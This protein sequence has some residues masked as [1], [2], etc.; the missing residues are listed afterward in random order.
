MK[1]I[2]YKTLDMFIDNYKISRNEAE[3]SRTDISAYDFI[4]NFRI[5]EKKKFKE[6][7]DRKKLNGTQK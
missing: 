3:K 1:D 7:Y 6:Y 5:E 4:D 2:I